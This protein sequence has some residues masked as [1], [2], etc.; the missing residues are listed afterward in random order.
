MYDVIPTLTDSDVL[1]FCKKGYILLEGVVSDDVNHKVTQFLEEHPSYEPSEI[2]QE[3]YFVNDVLLN[4]QVAGAVRSLLGKQF[5]L[6]VLISN[7]RA[8]G[9]R[10]VVGTWHRDGGAL[11]K[12]LTECNYLQVFYYPQATTVE[13]GPT[14]LLPGTHL[15]YHDANLM[16]HYGSF[17]NKVLTTSPAGSVFITSY[18]LWHRAASKTDPATRNLLKYNYWRTSPPER[19]WLVDPDFDFNTVQ[20][21]E[22]YKGLSPLPVSTEPAWAVAQMFYWLCGQGEQFKT[23]GG[24]SWPLDT[25]IGLSREHVLDLIRR[26]SQ[27]NS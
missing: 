26:V 12:G 19:D 3:D 23:L 8:V 10:N 1:E 14:A 2:L 25:H 15:V 9:Q 17:R 22:F 5:A 21:R 7:H 4:P 24:Q 11:D 16:G 6:P 27:L 18:G 20:Y 13:M